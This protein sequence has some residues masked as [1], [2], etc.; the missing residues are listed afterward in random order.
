MTAEQIQQLIASKNFPNSASS[1]RL[2]E[3]HISWVLLTDEYAYKIKKPLKFSFLDFSSLDQRKYYCERELVLNRRLAP[4]VYLQVLPIRAKDEGL[5]IGGDEGQI[6]DYTLQMKQLDNNRL[7]SKLL[8][9]GSVSSTDM[10]DL[11]G[12]LAHFHRHADRCTQPLDIQKQWQDFADMLHVKTTLGKLIGQDFT[13]LMEASV[14]F[15]QAFLKQH[16]PR[17]RERYEKGFCVDGHGDLHARNIFLLEQPV[18]FDCLEFDDHLRQEDLL[19]ELGFLCMDLDYH[20]Q[21]LLAD[22][23]LKAYLQH[24]LCIENEEDQKILLYYKLY[25]ANVR[26]KVSALPLQNQKPADVPK[27]VID[28]LQTYGQLFR[29]Y[30][31]ELTKP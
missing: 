21:S 1:V 23:F 31:Q 27:S 13:S 3:T 4:M 8:K 10:V 24:Y 2:L 20:G 25:R 30:F 6:I 17:L 22:H 5:F 28:S 15:S 11:A 18:V 26:M 14:K 9:E 29:Q 16:E 7:M 12:I 19:A